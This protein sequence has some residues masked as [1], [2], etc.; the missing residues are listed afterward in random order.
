MN[1]L[2][3]FTN[4][5]ETQYHYFTGCS[6]KLAFVHDPIFQYAVNHG[7]TWSAIPFPQ[8]MA[9]AIM[10]TQSECEEVL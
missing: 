2:V 6:S 3:A 10:V 7:F 5:V 9:D 8:D 1:M 4:E